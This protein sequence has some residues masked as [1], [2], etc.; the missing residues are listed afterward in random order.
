MPNIQILKQA[1]LIHVVAQL[2]FSALPQLDQADIEALHSQLAAIGFPDMVE[3]SLDEVELSFNA[4]IEQSPQRISRKIQRFVFKGEGNRSLVE[5]RKDQ[6][7]LKTTDYA[8]H[9]N[10]L[11]Q[12]F[13]I[14]AICCACLPSL[15]Q[16]L[17]HDMTLR[18]IDLIV[19][20]KTE[21]LQTLVK[22]TLLPP[23]LNVL[24]AEPLFGSTTK[25]MRTSP[26][27]QLRIEFSEI[28]TKEHRLTKILPDDLAE[29]DPRC[30][31][32]IKPL[33]HWEKLV[34]P[35]YGLLDAE[36]KYIASDKPALGNVKIEDEYQLLYQ[37][38]SSVFWDLITDDA[39]I[40][41][42]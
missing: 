3:A 16:A 26:N 42:S 6:L 21:V 29:H 17:L 20:K 34:A 22:D 14:F 37:S 32:S 12:W 4:N 31:L 7:I 24:D 27:C 11:P 30:G 36:H 1:P 35:S 8:G 9:A 25:I 19:P 28:P 39:K 15:K 23:A 38:I 10:F 18:Y 2:N 40:S 5:F 41:W 13:K 33:S